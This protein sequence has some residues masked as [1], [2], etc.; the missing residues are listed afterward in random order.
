MKYED[1]TGKR[2]GKLTVLEIA[3]NKSK[4]DKHKRWKCL[5]D[6]GNYTVK[7]SAHLKDGNAKSCGCINHGLSHTRLFTI[8]ASMKD[9]C[10]NK[11]HNQYKNYGARGITVCDEWRKT[12]LS[13]YSWALNNGYTDELSI[14]RINNDKGYCPDNCRWATMKEQQNNKRTNRVITYCGKTQTL[15]QWAEEIGVNRNTLLYRLKR[16]WTIERALSKH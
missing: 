1:L 2:F 11:S 15:T 12:F 7:S 9:R 13:F 4:T 16:G 8:W 5:C 6:C 10:Y 14:D 3:E